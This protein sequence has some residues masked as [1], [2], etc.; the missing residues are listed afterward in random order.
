VLLA[1]T[2]KRREKIEIRE[3]RI[4]PL[5]EIS[6]SGFE[7]YGQIM[8][9][10]G[11]VPLENLA[12]VSYWTKNVDLGPSEEKIDLG[13]LLCKRTEA[14]VTKMER[15]KLTSESFVSLSGQAIF[16]MAPADNRKEM[17]DL[18]R[19]RA[20]LLNGTLG[21]A[22]NKGTW[23]WPPIP[24]EKTAKFTLLRKGELSDPTD[25]KDLGLE[26]RLII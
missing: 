18:T 5:T 15:H 10:E 3:I 12:H 24:L 19:I 6:P 20:F 25:M 21:V 23:H 16:V 7:P 1:K 8:G 11:E 9:L 4:E 17:P 26:L 13:L 2:V 14:P 22:L